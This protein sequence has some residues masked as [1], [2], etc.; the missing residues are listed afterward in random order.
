MTD[1]PHL[2]SPDAAQAASTNG[3]APSL[4]ELEA[5]LSTPEI[6][7]ELHLIYDTID[8]TR[9]QVGALQLL[10]VLSITI[11]V[12]AAGTTIAYVKTRTAG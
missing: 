11:T 7:R 4:D 5:A 9:M 10:M 8:E 6:A 12:I 2:T 1:E 3:G